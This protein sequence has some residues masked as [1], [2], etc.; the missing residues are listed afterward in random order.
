VPAHGFGAVWEALSEFELFA[1]GGGFAYPIDERSLAKHHQTWV[2]EP[3]T[4]IW[5]LDVMRER[6]QGDMW[7]WRRD[8]RVRRPASQVIARTPDGIPYAKPE[9]AL[10]FKTKTTRDKD[11]EDFYGVLPLLSPEQRDWL[12]RALVL[13]DPE[14]PWLEALEA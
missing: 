4:G 7:V 1:V 12:A 13:S 2:R 10:L 3:G 8:P 6:W 9:I 11:Q 5:R 14:H